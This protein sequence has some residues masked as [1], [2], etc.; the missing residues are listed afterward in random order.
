MSEQNHFALEVIRK[1]IR[2]VPCRKLSCVDRVIRYAPTLCH[3]SAI[4]KHVATQH[5]FDNKVPIDHLFKVL[6]KCRS[7]FD[8]LVYEMLFVKD[9]KPTLNVQS[10]SIRAKLFT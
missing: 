6:K 1:V 5:D 8:C 10:D 4:G 7:K 9:I 3:Y 2:Y